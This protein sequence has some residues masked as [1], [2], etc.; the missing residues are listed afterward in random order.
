MIMIHLLHVKPPENGMA[1][2]RPVVRGALAKKGSRVVG[3][4]RRGPT[5]YGDDGQTTEG[6]MVAACM[7]VRG[8]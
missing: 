4:D 8:W 5:P 6:R 2:W 1:A 7:E 3:R